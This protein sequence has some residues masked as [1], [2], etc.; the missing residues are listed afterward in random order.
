MALPIIALTSI[1]GYYLSKKDDAEIEIT[2]TIKP[3]LKNNPAPYEIPNGKNIYS[4]NYVNEANTTILNKSLDLYKQ[5]EEPAVTGVLPPLFNTYSASGNKDFYKEISDTHKLNEIDSLNRL[6]DV[7]QKEESPELN[8][9]PMFNPEIKFKGEKIES[10]FS[11]FEQLPVSDEISLLTG[12]QIEREHTNMVP[13]FGSNVK[14]N[15]ETFTNQ[16]ILDLHSGNTSTFKHKSEIGKLFSEKPE[17]IY[18][19]PLFTNEIETDRFIS[20]LYKQ[21]E[22]PFQ[23]EKISAPISGTYENKILPSYKEVNELRPGNKPK[24]SYEAR[25][26]SGKMGEVRGVQSTVNKN[27]PDTFYEQGS[28][29]LIVTTGQ[30]IA[31]KNEEDYVTNF[32][33]TSREDYNLEYYGPMGSKEFLSTTQRIEQIDNSKE[34]SFN[35]LSQVPKRQNFKNDYLRNFANEKRVIDYGKTAITNYETERATTED[36]SQILNVNSTSRGFK[37]SFSDEAKST[38]KETTLDTDTTRNFKSTFDRGFVETH[39]SGISDFKTRTTNKETFEEDNYK[40]ITNKEKGMGYIVN[41]YDA[42]TTSKEIISDESE[43]QGNAKY[44]NNQMSKENFKNAVIRD[45][46]EELLERDRSSGPQN[47]QIYA[48]QNALGDLQFTENM[49]LKES[50]DER[51]KLNV[52]KPNIFPSKFSIGVSDRIK[53]DDDVEDTIYIDRMQSDIVSS[54]LDNNPFSMYRK[55]N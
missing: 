47:F 51:E 19:T 9:R 15:I 52:L 11:A 29:R 12:L 43:Y 35:S 7:T 28:D 53:Y 41:K 55:K 33:A 6:V 40:G 21:G 48:G 3:K 1:V 10:N 22:K 13:F 18:G 50:I 26:L 42:K 23:E 5:S 16:S 24:E 30:Y 17:N 31:K 8:S 37:T 27:R 25:T 14:Q 45:N 44:A 36:K 39:Y 49:K 54:Q 20:S 38:I 4:S 32:K 46:K 34:L 2:E